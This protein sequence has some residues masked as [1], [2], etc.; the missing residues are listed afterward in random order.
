MKYLMEKKTKEERIV[1]FTQ[2][3]NDMSPE[4]ATSMYVLGDSLSSEAIEVLEESIS[5][6]VSLK[7]NRTWALELAQHLIA[8]GQVDALSSS[9]FILSEIAPDKKKAVELLWYTL[10]EKVEGE[11]LRA[12]IDEQSRVLK[13]LSIE[14][15]SYEAL[16]D[17][18]A[19]TQDLKHR[20]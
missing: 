5:K 2:R 8:Y 18:A 15:Y 16:S 1:E 9:I 7:S 19:E 4:D 12:L 3:L 13:L 20:L 11:L 17:L 14:T 10:P 6:F